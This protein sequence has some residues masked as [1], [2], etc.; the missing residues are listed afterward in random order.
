MN[1]ELR[2]PP[3]IFS[4]VLKLPDEAVLTAAS[5]ACRVLQQPSPD[6]AELPLHRLVEACL[7]L[8]CKA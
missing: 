4:Q 7:Y 1:P 5:F 3:V 6:C 2:A 8:A